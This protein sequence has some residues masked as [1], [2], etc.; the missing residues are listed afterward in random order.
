MFFKLGRKLT[1]QQ[2]Q[3]EGQGKEG[4]QMLG[5]NGL[6]SAQQEIC[7]KYPRVGFMLTEFLVMVVII[8]ILATILFPIFCQAQGKTA[9]IQYVSN[10]EQIGSNFVYTSL[11]LTYVQRTSLF[12]QL[13]SQ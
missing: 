2:D 4:C 1:L 10:N 5:R 8:A 12:K 11:P 6:W 7:H 3:H 9:Q 13:E